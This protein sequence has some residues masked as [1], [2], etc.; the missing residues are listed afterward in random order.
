MAIR[1]SREVTTNQN[2][3]HELL[4]HVLAL[5]RERPYRKPIAAHSRYAFEQAQVIV[6]RQNKPLILDSGC[7]TGASTVRLAALFPDYFVLGI[8]KSHAR[9]SKN[10]FH[11][12]THPGNFL[13]VRADLIDFWRLA[14]QA[15]WEVERH[16]LLYP[17]PWPK[18]RQLRRRFHGH[19]VFFDL[20]RLGRYFELR[21]NWR[22]YAQEFAM[23]WMYA[24]GQ[25]VVVE[26][27]DPGTEP[28]S[29]FE[30]KYVASGHRLYRLRID[31]PDR[32]PC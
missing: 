4:L 20:V 10:P 3:P 16:Y 8:D 19:P 21:T 1:R 26:R 25:Q 18:R 29:T 11:L 5:H 13:L 9:L 6:A 14:V 23:A 31:R 22:I 17:N 27:F 28:L 2:G 30:K 15:G 7:G 24:T 12:H 32:S